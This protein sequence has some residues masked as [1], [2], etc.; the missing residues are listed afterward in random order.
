[1][2]ARPLNNSV[3]INYLFNYNNTYPL[4]GFYKY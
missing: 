3:G 1:M 4:R 2:S